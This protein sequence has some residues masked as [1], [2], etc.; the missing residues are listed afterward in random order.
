MSA[1][2]TFSGSIQNGEVAAPPPR[3]LPGVPLFFSRENGARRLLRGGEGGGSARSVRHELDVLGFVW[4]C[5]VLSGFV[6]FCL[7]LSGFVWFCL[8]LSGFVRFG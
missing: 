4:F 1:N 3:L 6:W 5:L 7:V 8:V 2:V